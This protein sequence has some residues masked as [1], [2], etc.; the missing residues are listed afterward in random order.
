M[1]FSPFLFSAVASQDPKEIDRSPSISF[2]S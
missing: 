2:G 1:L